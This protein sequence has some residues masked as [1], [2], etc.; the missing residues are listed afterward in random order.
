MIKLQQKKEK[1]KQWKEK[2]GAVCLNV[3]KALWV[4]LV[5]GYYVFGIWSNKEVIQEAKAADITALVICMVVTAG[6]AILTFCRPVLRERAGHIA[7]VISLFVLPYISFCLTEWLFQNPFQIRMAVVVSNYVIYL[8]IYLIAFAVT[9]RYRFAIIIGNTITFLAGLVNYFVLLFRGTPFCPWDIFSV[10]TAADVLE[11][12]TFTITLNLLGGILT[13]V[14]INM[15]A[16]S[17]KEKIHKLL[18]RISSAIVVVFAT[19]VMIYV[20]FLTPVLGN[21]GITPNLFMQQVGYEDNGYVLGFCL[22]IKY[23]QVNVPETYS[24]EK[25]EEI[26]KSIPEVEEVSQAAVKPNIIMIMNE[27]YVDLQDVGEFQTNIEYMPFVNGLTDNTVTGDLYV[28][29]Y[30]GGT[31]NTEYEVLTGNSTAFLANGCIP[32]Q[33]YISSKYKTGGMVSNLKEQGYTCYAVHPMSARN[34]ERDVVY[35]SMGF[36]KF[37]DIDSFSNQVYVRGVLTS[38]WDNYQKV[39]AL[40]K[41]RETSD[42]MFIFNVTVQNHGGYTYGTEFEE[43]VEVEDMEQEYPKVNE[44]LSLMKLSDN[45]LIYLIGELQQFEEPTLVVLFGDHHPAVEEEFY[46]ELIGKPMEEWNIEELQKRYQVPLVIWANYDIEEKDLG[47][48]SANMLASVVY[49]YAGLKMPKYFEFQKKL[50]QK[51]PVLN[52][53]GYMDEKGI[54]HKHTENSEYDTLLEEYRVLNYNSAVDLKHTV[55]Q[56]YAD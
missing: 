36:D 38:D 32:Y 24:V 26:L 9:N 51:I 43:A 17:L 56:L 3:L 8:A 28:S 30:G 54:M 49:E 15:W 34:W 31:S 42:P 35:E 20:L 52:V 25:T 10:G 40:L 1:L 29:V 12:Y 44:Y 55:K 14:L 39:V 19:G 46:E 45:A 6:I 18:I 41:E 16:F 22:N 11:G 5:V 4:I 33:Q 21:Y 53:N 23:I 37:F 50:S 48:L 13:V 7:G 47:A 2:H 27:A